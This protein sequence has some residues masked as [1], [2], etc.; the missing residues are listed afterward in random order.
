[1]SLVINHNLMAMNSARNLSDHYGQ[2]SVSTRRLSS[3]LRIGTAADDAAG[4]AIRELMRADVASLNQGV[5]NANDAISMIQVADGALQVIDEK[6]IRMNELAEQAATG[7]YNADQREIINSEY[8]QM[9]LEI[10]RISNATDFNGVHLLNGSLSGAHDGSSIQSTGAAKIHF[11]TGN[12]SAE[13]YYYVNINSSKVESLFDGDGSAIGVFEENRMNFYDPNSEP[14]QA[15]SA[16]NPYLGYAMVSTLADGNFV[17]VWE[18]T[19]TSGGSHG[20]VGQIMSPSGEPIG[21]N[22]QVNTETAGLQGRPS[23]SAL[24]NGDFVVVWYSENQDGSGL[25]VYSQRFDANGNKLATETRVNTSTNADQ[26]YPSVKGLSSGRYIVGWNS[27][28]TGTNE[29]YGKVYNNDGSVYKDEFLVSVGASGTG[30]SVSFAELEDG[31]IVGTYSGQDGDNWGVFAQMLNP[32]ANTIGTE[33]LVNED[34]Q[35]LQHRM[36]ITSLT[37]GK[38]AI[39]YSNTDTALNV[40]EVDVQLFNAD[41]TKFGSTIRVN[42]SPKLPPNVETNTKISRLQE[43]GFVVT[44][45]WNDGTQNQALMQMYDNNGNRIGDNY[46]YNFDD[47]YDHGNHEV[48]YLE[49][50]GFVA[51]YAM[52]DGTSANV[53]A[54]IFSPVLSVLTQEQAQTSLVKLHDAIIEKDKIRANLGAMQN[55]LENTISNLQIQAENLQSAESR[56]SDADVSQEM[57]E[58]VREQILTQAAT[59]M[60]TQANSLPKMALQIIGG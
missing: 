6:L 39:S 42:D 45:S 46:T 30:F 40:G 57:T 49:T 3:G 25:G 21:Q 51:L 58:F 20:I 11:G 16:D 22:F 55:R 38:F 33:I 41:G 28:H 53:Y 47:G 50:G 24:T 5:R 14:I 34:T 13:D 35:Y 7:T 9:A 26:Y 32:D 19:D 54:R 36:Y 8:L 52:N 29:I 37:D 31:N 15:S 60:L 27:N 23:V 48:T 2:L 43:G 17:S 56:I 12:C 44:W 10:Q 1:M 18:S 4:L 59:A